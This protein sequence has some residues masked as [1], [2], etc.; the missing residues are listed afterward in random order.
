MHC[1][2]PRRPDQGPDCS[3]V[4]Y[5]RAERSTA[6]RT[7][8]ISSTCIRIDASK[9]SRW[10]CLTVPGEQRDVRRLDTVPKP[11]AVIVPIYAG[12]L[13]RRPRPFPT[14]LWRVGPGHVVH[15][16]NLRR[17]I[18]SRALMNRKPRHESDLRQ[19]HFTR[20]H[21]WRHAAKGRI[22]QGERVQL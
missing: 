13:H 7:S 14:L 6:R 12:F 8:F 18:F 16:A 21:W 3:N 15:R 10:S 4:H 17:A 2:C 19:V 20:M 1:R 22:F 11:S 5:L 9:S